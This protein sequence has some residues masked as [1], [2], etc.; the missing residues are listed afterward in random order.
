MYR[1]QVRP[2]HGSTKLLIELLPKTAD[3]TFFDE[4]LLVLRQVNA[5]VADVHDVWMNDEVWLSFDSDVGPFL[6][7]KDI[8][9][10]VFIMASENQAAILRIADALRANPQFQS[11][12]ADF[13][14]RCEQ[15]PA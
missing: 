1:Y 15:E 2:E 13:D 8:W 14:E 11:E 10:L 6:V 4:L 12:V 5:K 7:T 3:Q 9:G